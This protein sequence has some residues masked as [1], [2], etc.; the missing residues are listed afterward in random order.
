MYRI[1]H[2]DDRA[3]LRTFMNQDAFVYAYA[4][5]DLDDVNWP[6]SDFWCAFAGEQLR[7]FVLFFHGFEIPSL[8]LGGDAKAVAAIMKDISLPQESFCLA[9]GNFDDLLTRYYTA[10]HLHDLHRMVLLPGE[11]RACGRALPT[12]LTLQRLH[13][14]HTAMLNHLY[15]QAAEPGEN[16][17]A[18]SPDQIEQ[19]VFM[20]AVAAQDGQLIAAAGTHIASQ[21]ENI[22][23]VG[24][25][26]TQPS[27][28]GRGLAQITTSA[29]VAV[30]FGMGI[31]RVVLNVKQDNLPAIRAYKNLGFRVYSDFIEGPAHLLQ[32]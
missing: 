15:A 1:Q 4:L 32:T 25:V 24:N 5:G 27:W 2:C 14:A 20:G 9:P 19:G 8:T 16:V 22:A 18:F 17:V 23:A 31:S 26:F 11:F 12:P 30:L 10:P 6:H 21:A 29:V 7:G 28:R 13:R 3:L